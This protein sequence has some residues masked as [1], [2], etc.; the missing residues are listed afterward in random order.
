VEQIEAQ[1]LFVTRLPPSTPRSAP[2]RTPQKLACASAR[3]PNSSKRGIERGI[4]TGIQMHVRFAPC[5]CV[6]AYDVLSMVMLSP[7]C[8]LAAKIC[9]ALS[10]SELALAK[11]APV[12]RWRCAQTTPMALA[13]V[14]WATQAPSASAMHRMLCIVSPLP[15][16][17]RGSSLCAAAVL[18]AQMDDSIATA[19]A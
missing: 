19:P 5:G 2:R 7:G 8:R 16:P 15:A 17:K 11:A 4:D 12:T 1:R 13:R 18:P 14:R 10:V 6:H 9:F 3:A